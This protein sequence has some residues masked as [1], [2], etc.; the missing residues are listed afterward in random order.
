MDIRS[1]VPYVYQL[2]ITVPFPVKVTNSYALDTGRGFLLID[3]GMDGR[4]ARREWQYYIDKL[5]LSSRTVRALFVTH[6]HPDH[7]GLSAWATEQ[8]QAP[9][10]LMNGE[11]LSF[12]EVRHG[13]FDRAAI[14]RQAD[15]WMSHGVPPNIA[16]QW[17]HAAKKMWSTVPCPSE[18]NPVVD[19]TEVTIGRFTFRVIEQR[20]HSPHQGVLYESHGNLLFTGDQILTRITPN[21]GL[22]SDSGD[23]NPLRAYLRSLDILMDL[24]DC[25]GLPAHEG[26][27][28]STHCRV[29]EIKAH[30]RQRSQQVKTLV[31]EHENSGYVLARQLF[32]RPLEGEQLR[33]ALGETLA[34]LEFL[35]YRGH[36]TRENVNGTWVYRAIHGP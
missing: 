26:L 9:L 12:A 14:I 22:Y 6:F 2:P 10:Y 25:L 11:D 3:F 20:G 17:H 18:M 1:P 24:P 30:H 34:H 23:Q 33:L 16:M 8:F 19:G 13:V 28:A 5:G 35:R 15:F 27:I 7:I 31:V 32:T 21:V 4:L 29:E 36:V